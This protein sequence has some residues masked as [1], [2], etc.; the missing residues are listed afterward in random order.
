[1]LGPKVSR[2]PQVSK[3]ASSTG[4][5]PWERAI[6]DGR[7]TDKVLAEATELRITSESL[8]RFFL[9]QLAQRKR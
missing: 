6:V 2:H 4:Q 1:M 7:D 9:A 3:S 5:V 8:K